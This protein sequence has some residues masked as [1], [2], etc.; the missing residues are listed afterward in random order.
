MGNVV[1]IFIGFNKIFWLSD[2]FDVVCI[3]CFLFEFWIIEYLKLFL[4]REAKT[5]EEA[6]RIA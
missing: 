6:E 3:N 5:S 1:K 4:A 2:M